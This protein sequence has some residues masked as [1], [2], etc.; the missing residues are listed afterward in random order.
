MNVI[1]GKRGSPPKE[2]KACTHRYHESYPSC[3]FAPHRCCLPHCTKRMFPTPVRGSTEHFL[4]VPAPC[5]KQGQRLPTRSA[6]QTEQNG[7][8]GRGHPHDNPIRKCVSAALTQL[9]V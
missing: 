2:P 6:A 8:S 1:K 4:R 9:P 7:F 5:R 3:A